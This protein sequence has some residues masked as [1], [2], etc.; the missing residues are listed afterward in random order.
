MQ[1]ERQKA[2]RR[3]RDPKIIGPQSSDPLRLMNEYV[4]GSAY[5]DSGKSRNERLDAAI[6]DARESGRPTAAQ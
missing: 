3:R 2:A 4:P 1:R 5:V 6:L